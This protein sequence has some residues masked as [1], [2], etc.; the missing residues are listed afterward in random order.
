MS[1]TFEEV[2]RLVAAG[3]WLPTTHALRRLA[4]RQILMADVLDGLN[5]AVFVED[6]PED[7]RGQSILLLSFDST[8]LPIH[9][10]WGIP[11]KDRG[12]ANLVTIYHPDPKEWYGD[13]IRRK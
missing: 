7:P 13:W 11:V 9:A 8:N 4:E 5:S 3:N 1:D 10:L 6:Y 12:I 2:R